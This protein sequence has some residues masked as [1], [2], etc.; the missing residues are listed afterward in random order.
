[1]CPYVYNSY[2]NSG[3]NLSCRSDSKYLNAF[4]NA[5]LYSYT[6]IYDLPICLSR[7][8]CKGHE[9]LIDLLHSDS[10]QNQLKSLSLHFPKMRNRFTYFNNIYDLLLF[11][12][13]L[14]SCYYHI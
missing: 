3:A 13:T 7:D 9:G 11:I 10:S 4:F 5:N 1:M 2:K 12:F 14:L 6:F 8:S